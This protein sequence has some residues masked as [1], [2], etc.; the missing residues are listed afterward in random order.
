MITS[1]LQR[2]TTD[3]TR[4][5]MLRARLAAALA[6]G[7]SPVE[8]AALLQAAGYRIGPEHLRQEETALDDDALDGVSGGNYVF[9]NP[10]SPYRD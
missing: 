8:A 3:L 4:D 6:P 1:E 7:A 10:K 2:L 5:P 9:Q